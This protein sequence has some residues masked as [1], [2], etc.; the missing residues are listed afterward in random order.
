MKKKIN[1]FITGY[2]TKHAGEEEKI[3]EFSMFIERFFEMFLK[4]MQKYTPTSMKK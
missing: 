1:E 3:E 2:L 4:N